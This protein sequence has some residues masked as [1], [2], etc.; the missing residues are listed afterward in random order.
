V[1]VTR[2]DF[3][4]RSGDRSMELGLASLGDESI[5]LHLQNVEMVLRERLSKDFEIDVELRRVNVGLWWPH[6]GRFNP[7]EYVPDDYDNIPGKEQFAQQ[8]PLG[9]ESIFQFELGEGED[10]V[11]PSLD[12]LVVC[13][14]KT[15]QNLRLDILRFDSF[16]D[17]GDGAVLVASLSHVSVVLVWDGRQH[18]D[19][20]FCS[21]NDKE[22]LADYFLRSFLYYADNNLKFALRDDF[23]RGVGR[24]VNF[25]SD[26]DTSPGTKGFRLQ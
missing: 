20:N 14:E 19:V 17:V 22:A 5:F 11:F 24:V 1:P 9:S 3:V 6:G 8:K 23:P 2:A 25:R 7:K 26:I 21:T 10:A 12:E 16:T 4:L 13:F 18:V 15:L